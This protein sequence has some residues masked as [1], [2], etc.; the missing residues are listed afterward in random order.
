MKLL[1]PIRLAC[2]DRDMV[3]ALCIRDI[4]PERRLG[5]LE[6]I[7]SRGPGDRQQSD[8]GV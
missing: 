4:R 8:A 7:S 5:G 3:M 6:L 1:R 2:T